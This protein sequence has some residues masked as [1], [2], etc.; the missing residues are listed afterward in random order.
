MHTNPEILALLALGE[1]SAASE[2]DR[3]HIASCAI[4][5]NE[6]AELGHLAEVGRAAKGSDRLLTPDPRVWDRIR[7]EIGLKDH[8]EH[9]LDQVSLVTNPQEPSVASPAPE[10][11]APGGSVPT[12]GA[13]V[14]ELRPG[15]NR[16]GGT[17]G[18]RLIA[19]A[20]AAAVALVAGVGIGLGI[21][22]LRRPEPTV[23]D[24]TELAPLPEWPDSSGQATLERDAD[25]VRI[26]MV[27]LS[28]G[29][30][31]DGRQQGWLIDPDSGDMVTLGLMSQLRGVWTVPTNVDLQRYRVLDISEEPLNDSDPA[32]SRNSIVRGTLTV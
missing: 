9:P 26:L 25:G 13:V 8:V 10:P 20:V 6:V 2:A 16:K 17:R 4:C 7:E 3:S 14:H 18:R 21:D 12:T 22:R 23:L 24:R 19:L 32:H 29:R 28:T 5:T 31:L 1:D 30:P 15:A 11:V 27:D